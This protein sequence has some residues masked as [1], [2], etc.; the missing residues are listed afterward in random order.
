MNKD[1][2]TI[3]DNDNNKKEYKMLFIIEKEYKY[4]IYTDLE[5]N[6]LFKKLYAVKINKDNNTLE[7][8]NDEWQMIENEYQKLLN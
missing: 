6:N 1:I 3:Y 5:N 4:I 8:N 7:I 2:I